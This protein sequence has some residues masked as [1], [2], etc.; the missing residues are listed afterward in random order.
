MSAHHTWFARSMVRPRHHFGDYGE[1]EPKSKGD[2]RDTRRQAVVW[3]TENDDARRRLHGAAGKLK[4]RV[5]DRLFNSTA[6]IAHNKFAVYIKDGKPSSLWP[7]ARIGLRP[8][9]DS[10]NLCRRGQRRDI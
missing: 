9:G 4:G 6:R 5:I 2:S 3:D 8:V 7:A 1:P 10:A